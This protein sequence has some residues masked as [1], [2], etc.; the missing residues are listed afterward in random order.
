M[1]EVDVSE[2]KKVVKKLCVEANYYL[3]DDVLDALKTNHEKE[4]SQVGKEVY[5]QL[6]ENAEIAA[7]EQ[8]P[9]CQDT[10]FAVVFLD[11][12][13][14]VHLVGGDLRET[15][16]EGIREG[17]KEGYLRKSICDPFTRKNTGDNTPI[18]LH[19]NIV[20]G[21]KIHVTVGAKGGGSENMSRVMMMKPS[22]GEEGIKDYVVQRCSEAGSNP[23]PP[24][25][26]GVGIGGTFEHAAYLAKRS[27]FREIGQRNEDPKLAAIE[28]E[29]LERINALGIGPQ[30]MGGTKFCLD[31]FINY[32]PCH[33]AS[34]PLAVNIDCHAHRHKEAVI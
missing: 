25:V 1:R 12:G 23:C 9:I 10:G 26:V 6:I 31:V 20:P 7:R 8:S 18:I 22:D 2:I 30:G 28:E 15:V 34:L 14:D 33:I 16:T 24:I 32:H 3:E 17:Y 11:I 21:D 13:Q 5:R 29:L 19:T 4:E 27:L